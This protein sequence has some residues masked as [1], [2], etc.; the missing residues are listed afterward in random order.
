MGV[1]VISI[2]G[3]RKLG[4]RKFCPLPGLSLTEGS[5]FLILVVEVGY[6]GQQSWQF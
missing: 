6:Y 2:L 4:P 5:S 3:V 1:G